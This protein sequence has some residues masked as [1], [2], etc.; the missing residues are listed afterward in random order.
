MKTTMSPVA[1]SKRQP[2]RVALALAAVEDDARAVRDGDVARAVP[3]VAVDDQHLVGV[4][5][6][7]VDDLADQ[8]FFILGGDDNGDTWIG[9]RLGQ[10][11]V[12]RL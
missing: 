12:W 10:S 11:V 6:H 8:P 3:R 7:R 1:A 5:L 4:R 2:Q 9:H